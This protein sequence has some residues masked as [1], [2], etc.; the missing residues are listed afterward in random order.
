MT[1]PNKQ[2]TGVLQPR[3]EAIIGREEQADGL[4]ARKDQSQHA[5]AAGATPRVLFDSETEI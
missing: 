2:G 4:L 3:S 1:I 5:K